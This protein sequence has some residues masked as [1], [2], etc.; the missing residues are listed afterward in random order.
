MNVKWIIISGVIVLAMA[1]LGGAFDRD[2]SGRPLIA[3][4][5]ASTAIPA[6]K[7]LPAYGQCATNDMR[8]VDCSAS[9]AVMTMEEFKR[10]LKS[11]CAALDDKKVS[12]MTAKEF[13]IQGACTEISAR[14]LLD[15]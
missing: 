14:H 7:S 15:R 12:D 6:H 8:V 3:A 11:L 9:D 4:E 13:R 2:Y 10:D 5:Q 1:A